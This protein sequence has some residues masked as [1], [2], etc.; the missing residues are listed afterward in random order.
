LRDRN[1]MLAAGH[2]PSISTAEV[3]SG[4]MTHAFC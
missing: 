1:N 3:S 4:S 2:K